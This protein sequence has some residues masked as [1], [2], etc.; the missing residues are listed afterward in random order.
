M[1]KKPSRTRSHSQET[2][3]WMSVGAD[4]V[5][6]GM[7]IGPLAAPFLAASQFLILPQIAAIIYFMGQHVCPQPDMGVALS[8]PFIMAVCM[9][10]YGTIGG[11]L[12]TRVLYA[13]NHGQGIYW[14]HQ[15]GWRGVWFASG[16]MMVYPLELAAQVLGWW[17]FDQ[18]VV[19]VCGLVTGLG[20]GLLTMPILHGKYPKMSIAATK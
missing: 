18:S 6:A 8:P 10:C 3:N 12:I 16:F 19:T 17:G 14:L 7:V 1:H 2:L 15:Y 9:R 13:I 4:T 20:W 5:L 11:L